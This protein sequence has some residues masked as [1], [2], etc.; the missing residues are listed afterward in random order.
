MKISRST[1]IQWLKVI[2]PILLMVFAIHEIGKIIKEA[3][4]EKIASELGAI[5]VR[6]L[7]LIAVVPLILAFPMFFYDFFIVKKL[8]IKNPIKKLMKESLIINSF[9][10]L[11]GFGGLIGVL[12]RTH[13]FKKPEM[14]NGA[15][16]KTIA[17]VTLFYLAGISLFADILVIGFWQLE[18]FQ[19]HPF[20]LFVA[21]FIGL[22]TPFLFIK[23]LIQL[24]LKKVTMKQVLGDV[25]LVGVSIVEWL[26]AFCMLVILTKLLHIEVS[27]FDL[28]PVFVIASAAGI[29]SMIPGGLGSF[30]LVFIWGATELNISSE[31]VLV[32][33]LCY[34]IGYY[35][36]PFIA[37][38][39]LF[40]RDIWGTF[41]IGYNSIP[42]G[43]LT[44]TTHIIATALVFLAGLI[45]LIS[46]A[47]PGAIE[48][49][50]FLREITSLPFVNVS[51]QVSVITGFVLLTLSNGISYKDKR[52]FKL[53]LFVLLFAAALFILKGVQYRQALFMLFVALLLYLSK[54]RFYRHSYVQTWGRGVLNTLVI[55][56]ILLSYLVLGFLAL[57]ESRYKLSVRVHEF[58]SS[59]SQDLFLSA[60][61]GV[62]VVAGVVTFEIWKNKKTQFKK[63]YVV[64][65]KK[66]I[67]EHLAIYGGKEAFHFET[68]EKQCF[69]WNERQTVLFPYRVSADKLIV[70]GDLVGKQQDFKEAVE[71]FIEFA[72]L[73]GYTPV[74]YEVS[75]HFI[76]Y[77]YGYGYNFFRLGEEGY[78]NIKNLEI[79]LDEQ[80]KYDRQYLAMEQAG[81]HFELLRAPFTHEF[82]KQ[83]AQLS[84][85]WQSEHEFREESYLFDEIY[86]NSGQIAVLRNEKNQIVV[87]ANLIPLHDE[88]N[89]LVISLMRIHHSELVEHAMDFMLFHVLMVAKQANYGRLNLGMTYLK[90]VGI[91]KYAGISEKIA[92]QIL[93]DAQEPT[94]HVELQNLKEQYA[95]EW[96]PKYLA[97]RKRVFL[98]ITMVQIMMLIGV[99]KLS[100]KRNQ[101]MA[102]RNLKKK[103]SK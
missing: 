100:N 27:V 63:K 20:L 62:V 99:N 52:S 80:H 56:L 81:Y 5:D 2:L 82:A 59:D 71:E 101:L 16:F 22:Y 90:H 66:E 55:S 61:I 54:N 85:N 48:K 49:L 28:W 92:A 98:P 74:F 35:V 40:I 89:T 95:D 75:N 93:V 18:L 17:S 103:R 50:K 70:L 73:Y 21:G 57:E 96:N 44:K 68:H 12:L 11:I 72:D 53:T 86:L 42:N 8:K 60:I 25:L 69:Y 45:L 46:T 30:D 14:E 3:N 65:H 10:N 9:S 37:G 41:N 47:A 6:A 1:I 87:F 51:H 58:L 24:I 33:L 31:T 34:R 13:Y 43:L 78:I 15:F 26:G 102:M 94:V 97:Y 67:F 19:E 77:L 7:V 64:D 32:L 23:A 91:S 38:L 79:T 36:I 76:P 29:V 88:K 83:L 4:G 39:I 84:N